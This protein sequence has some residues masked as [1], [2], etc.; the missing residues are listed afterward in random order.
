L[1]IAKTGVKMIPAVIVDGQVKLVG[2]IPEI[3]DV[4]KWIRE[5]TPQYREPS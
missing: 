2:K 4:L 3:E 5:S 1:D